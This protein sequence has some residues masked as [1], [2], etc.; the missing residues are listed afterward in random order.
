MGGR[1]LNWKV[2]VKTG[3]EKKMVLLNHPFKTG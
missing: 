2:T 3:T 1:E